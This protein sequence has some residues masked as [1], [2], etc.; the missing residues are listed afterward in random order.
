M[1]QKNKNIKKGSSLRIQIGL[2][3]TIL[4][5]V[6]IVFFSVMIFENQSDLLVRSFKFQSENLANT[7]QN[8]LSN[9][10]IRIQKNTEQ[11]AIIDRL[12]LYEIDNFRIYDKKGTEVYR[13]P[14]EIN[15]IQKIEPNEL[16]LKIQS[17]GIGDSGSIF[18]SRY[19]LELNQN[20]FS[21]S[22]FIPF[23]DA[24][25]S[26]LYL[27][28]DVKLSGIQERLNQ[29]YVFMA[30]AT[31]WGILFHVL[32]AIFVYRVIFKRLEIL[33]ST[34]EKM[35]EGELSSR[36]EWEFKRSDELD[37]LG[38]SFNSMA[39]KIE[40]TVNT[41]TRL[42]KE[43]NL[44]LTIGK[45]VQELF[46][47]K[48]KKYKKF[49][50]GLLYRPM[51]EVSGDIYQCF[52]IENKELNKEDYCFFLAD[53]SGHGISAA[54]VTVVIA[55]F[56]EA[57]LR[58]TNDA[59]KTIQKL[60]ELM[61][62]RLQASFFATS[63]FLNINK[64]NVLT[65]CNGG[66][67]SPYIIR[68]KNSEFIRIESSGPPLG[69]AEDH[70]YSLE[71]FQLEPGDRIFLYTDGLV[72]TQGREGNQFGLERSLDLIRKNLSKSNQEIVDILNTE[73][74]DFALEFKDDVSVLIIEIPE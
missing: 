70:N 56:L 62:S 11:S 29:I 4:A 12:R 15:Y 14:N 9:A 46:L 58:E 32:F 26:E 57:V 7:V 72:E 45:E 28:T 17:V 61:G 48:L 5:F 21:V 30:L 10:Q 20:D 37:S 66:H 40:E 6:N 63:V 71:T 13:Y 67:N 41:V 64:D 52:H 1:S 24:D 74:N 55:M 34:S 47:P 42:N 44:E 16:Q 60:S 53:A 19:N 36:A 38:L 65:I 49:S 23:I 18:K 3:Y 54:L 50:L 51:R 27:E 68:K 33:K 31:S 22:A 43:I 73:L 25:K 35:A 39:E 69:M 59:D 8:D 2:L